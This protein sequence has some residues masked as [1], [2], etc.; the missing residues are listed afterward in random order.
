M[1]QQAA[2]GTHPRAVLEHHA[3]IFIPVITPACL[4][5]ELG[6]AAAS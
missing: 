6:R 2:Q 5:L 3:T 4:N 1:Q